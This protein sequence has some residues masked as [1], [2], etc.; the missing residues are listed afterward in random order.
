MDGGQ[1]APTTGATARVSGVPTAQ[2]DLQ[3]GPE[4]TEH[5][6]RGGEEEGKADESS[7][8]TAP[9]PS[10]AAAGAS[11]QVAPM[12]NLY[13]AALSYNG[14]TVT[15]G[16]LRLIV[17]LHAAD[18]GF[19]AIEIAF[20]FSAYEVAGVFT[21][22]F[23]GV[24]GSKYGLRFTLLTSLV[25]QI[26]CLS[27]LTQTEPVLGDL[28]EAT[29]GSRRYLEATIYITAWQAL[30]GVA[31]DFMKLTGKATPKLVTKEGAE[32]RLF[33]VVAW[34][35]GMKNAL[36]GFGSFLGALLVAQIGYV[37]SLWILVGICAFFVPVGI[38]GMDRAELGWKRELVGLIMAGYIV[39]YG[40][41]QAAST[42]LYKNVDGTGGQPSGAAAYKWA[43]YCSLAPL[44]TGIASYFTHKVAD[45]QLATGCVLVLGMLVFA[46]L[47]A[48]NSSVHSYL[49]VS[50]SNKDKVAMDLGFYYM[51]NAMGRLIGVLVGGFLYHYTSDDFGLSMCLVVACPFLV[52]ASAIAYRLP[53][54]ATPPSPTTPD[55]E[56]KA[57]GA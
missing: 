37:N 36:K 25:L 26:I 9:E 44:I 34:L 43:A 15:D 30:A 4:D 33:Q 49:I 32:G 1:L 53:G 41:L 16:A 40:N 56:L 5:G 17:L 22:L 20:M 6:A 2:G 7:M 54:P 42:K 24:A 48:V 12:R 19:N 57:A 46:G 39:F 3:K 8:A 29:P 11:K 45:S 21:N 18:L 13:T 27:A 38:F 52:A 51:A 23:G 47:F 50:Y 55:I 28:R 10:A 31:K 35:T 14:Y